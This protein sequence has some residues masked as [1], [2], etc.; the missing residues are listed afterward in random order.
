[1]PDRAANLEICSAHYG[2]L[3]CFRPEGHGGSHSGISPMGQ[4]SWDESGFDPYQT[5]RCEEFPENPAPGNLAMTD[6][7]LYCWSPG[8]GWA[9]VPPHTF[10]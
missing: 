2:T 8:G 4:L 7:V 6:D 9:K 3:A 5:I 1:M 10:G